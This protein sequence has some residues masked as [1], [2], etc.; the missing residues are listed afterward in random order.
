VDLATGNERKQGE[1]KAYTVEK[2]MEAL[3][4]IDPKLF[5]AIA[6]GGMEPDVIIAQA[7]KSLATNSGNIGQLNITPDFLGGLLQ[8]N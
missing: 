8:R 5:E 2:M 7:F 6:A 3:N 1:A 4:K